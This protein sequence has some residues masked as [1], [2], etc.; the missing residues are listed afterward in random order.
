MQTA[1]RYAAAVF[2]ACFDVLPA[3]AENGSPII[4]ELEWVPRAI[5]LGGYIFYS[6]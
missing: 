3:L 5:R 4:P 1:T 6:F 2:L